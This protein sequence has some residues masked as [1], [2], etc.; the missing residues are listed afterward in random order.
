MNPPIYVPSG[1]AK[2]Y[3]DF[4]INIYSGCNH[5]CTY[6]FAPHV[7]HKTRGQFEAVRPREG[8]LAALEAQLGG[9]IGGSPYEGKTIHLCFTCDPY[10]AGIDTTP[11]REVI[12]L[13]KAAGCH[14]Q[15]LTKGGRRAVRD[16][17]LLD[18]EDWFGVT[19]SG[20][21]KEEPGAAPENERIATLWAAHSQ[22]IKTWISFE[23]VYNPETVYTAIK[24]GAWIDRLR[25]GKLNYFPSDID[26]GAF[27]RECERLARE[28][29]RVIY[30]KEDLRREMERV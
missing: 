23:P 25:I 17:D 21:E 22:G 29:G 24:H 14:V 5:G 30:I 11:T 2:E 15:I 6:C 16:M 26:W 10:P 28:H 27:G 13:L 1:R 19:I 3:G 12:K 18:G 4:C 20:A 8:L 9:L 7:L